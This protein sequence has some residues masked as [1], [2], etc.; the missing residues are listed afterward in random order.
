MNI[1]KGQN[2]LLQFGMESITR[3]YAK[4]VTKITLFINFLYLKY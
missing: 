2:D 4:F 3:E 1:Y